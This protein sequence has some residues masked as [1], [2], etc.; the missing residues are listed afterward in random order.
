MLDPL[1]AVS[2][3]GPGGVETHAVLLRALLDALGGRAHVQISILQSEHV[4]A[5]PPVVSFAEV[6]HPLLSWQA[7][8]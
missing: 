5:V 8:L 1:Y 7:S 2:L 4:H 3:A 6:N